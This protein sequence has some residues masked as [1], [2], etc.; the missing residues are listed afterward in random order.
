MT[1]LLHLE[2][3]DFNFTVILWAN[4]MIHWFAYVLKAASEEHALVRGTKKGD[5]FIWQHLVV[6]VYTGTYPFRQLCRLGNLRNRH[7]IITSNCLQRLVL[8]YDCLRIHKHILP[9]WLYPF[10]GIPNTQGIFSLRMA[11]KTK[12]PWLLPNLLKVYMDLVGQMWWKTISNVL[13]LGPFTSLY[14]SSASSKF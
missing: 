11:V 4:K 1:K 2:E 9:Q 13:S 12:P 8:I 14:L 7:E 10:Q 6:T 5:D 3:K